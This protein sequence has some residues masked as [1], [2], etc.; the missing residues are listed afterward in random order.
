MDEGRPPMGPT[1]EGKLEFSPTQTQEQLCP[2]L[3]FAQ[4]VAYQ[5]AIEEV[6]WRHRIWPKENPGPKP[7]LDAIVSPRQVEH[8]VEEY[9]RRSQLVAAQRGW[10]ITGSELQAEMER[11]ASHTRQRETLSELFEAL[12]NDPFLIAECLARPILGLRIASRISATVLIFEKLTLKDRRVKAIPQRE[13]DRN[14][15]Q[16]ARHCHKRSD[17]NSR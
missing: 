11:M 17:P 1:T 14:E 6:Y 16:I 7:P 2:P 12:G 15:L 3:T 4:R 5:Y 13:D 8:K 9:L 10:P